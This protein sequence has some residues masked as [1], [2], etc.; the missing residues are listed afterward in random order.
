MKKKILGL[1]VISAL[2]LP[3]TEVYALESSGEAAANSTLTTDDSALPTSSSTTSSLENGESST[4]TTETT[5]SSSTETVPESSSSQAVETSE[6]TESTTTS[7][8]ETETTASSEERQ[9]ANLLYSG[10]DENGS[11]SLPRNR[12]DIEPGIQYRS[13]IPYVSADTLTT[14]TKSFIDISSHNGAV[15]VNDFKIMKKYGV[16]GVSIKL[17][18]FTTYTN[19]YASIQIKNAKAAGMK[20]SAYHYSWFTSEKEARA[21]AEYFAAAARK[22]GLDSSTVMINDI[23]EPQIASYQINHTKNSLA[24]QKRLNELG[25]GNV[26]H[27]IGLYWLNSGLINGSTLGQKNIWVAAYPYT[28]SKNNYYTAYGAWQWNSQLSFPGVS[29][30]FDISA[31]YTN[32]YS[33]NEGL[34]NYASHVINTGWQVDAN[35]NQVSGTTGQAKRV[36]AIKLSLANTSQGGI[37]YQTHVQDIGW[38]S[39][40]KSNGQ[41]SGTTGKRK[42]VEAMK[43]RLTGNMAAKYDIY[44]RVHSERFGW[45]NWAKNGAEAGTQGFGYEVEAYQVQLVP[46]GEAAPSGSGKS[47]VVYQDI[48]L[49]Y[50]A[51]VREKGWQEYVK[52]GMVAGTTGQ[53]LPIEAMK[54]KVTS[55]P[56]GLSGAIEYQLHVAKDG[57][58]TWKSND[59]LGG[60]VGRALQA[61][62]IRIKLSGNLGTHYDI[63]YRVH[64]T[65]TGW[66][67][68]TKNGEPAGSERLAKGMEAIEVKIVKKHGIGPSSLEPAFL[69]G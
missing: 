37:Q 4:T 20:V 68:W 23:E 48:A 24:F 27:Y 54:F 66:L 5:T 8:E 49:Q 67:G 69:K 56:L 1:L 21:E 11:Y 53:A 10:E 58:Q 57:W 18:E 44:Y 34:V 3:Q 38:E 29:G 7:S 9:L 13:S 19:E 50:Q 28:V 35:N 30:S 6:T 55:N 15:S 43:I 47:F 45:L 17:T 36:E 32:A 26:R 14:P 31:D 41:I 62:A 39:T 63:F 2:L 64:I 61:E 65:D 40:W 60:T 59:A 52:T 12:S 25:F 46:K 33:S 22:F 51:H 16:T 42:Q